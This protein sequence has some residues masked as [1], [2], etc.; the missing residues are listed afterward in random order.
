L[1][2]LLLYLATSFVGK[3]GDAGW[4]FVFRANLL[5]LPGYLHFAFPKPAQ[6]FCCVQHG[7]SICKPRRNFSTSQTNQ[8]VFLCLELDFAQE[9]LANC[10]NPHDYGCFFLGPRL[11]H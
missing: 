11:D 2:L 7:Y 8:R 10:Q 3:L 1:L 4:P 6:F 5:H 9:A